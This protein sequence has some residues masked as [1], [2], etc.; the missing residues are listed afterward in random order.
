MGA[1]FEQIG[2]TPPAH[3]ADKAARTLE[4]LASACAGREEV[5][6]LAELLT[7][8]APVRALL[9]S[10]FG[11]SPYLT[12]LAT[13][14]PEGLQD[15]LASD[16]HD[17]FD[18]LGEALQQGMANAA[19]RDEAM[20][21]LRLYKQRVALWLA[22]ADIG[23][24]WGVD[25]VTHVLSEAAGTAISAAVRYLFAQAAQAGK[26]TPSDPA[27]PEA[28]SG[29]FVLGLGKLGAFE[30][31]Y[32]SDVDLIIFYDTQRAA[33]ADG[34]EPAPFFVRL[35]RDLVSLLQERTAA[36]YVFRTDLRLRPD[37]GATQVAL[38]TDAGFSY[39]ESFGQNWERAAL[40]KA[41]VVAGDH[42]AGEEFLEQLAPFV[43]RKYLDYAAIADI[44]TMKRRVHEFKGHG[45]IAVAG[46][47]V[48]LGRGGIR[49]IEF[50]VQTHQLIAGGRQADLRSRGTLETLGKLV[51]RNWIDAEAA[52]ELAEAYRYLRHVEHRIQ[53]IADEQTHKIPKGIEDLERVAHFSGSRDARSFGDE[54]V[55]YLKCVQGHY[56]GLFERLPEGASGGK[57]TAFRGDDDNPETMAVL[58]EFGFREPAKLLEVV[59]TWRSGRYAAMRSER[60]RERLNEMLPDLLEALG[61]TAEPDSALAAFDRFLAELPAGVQLFSLLGANTRL[62]RLIADIM[63]TAPRLASVLGRRAQVLDAVLDPGFFGDLPPSDALATLVRETVISSSDYQ[64]GLDQA[65]VVGAEQAFLIGV[66]VLSGTI[67]AEQAGGAYA[68]LAENLIAGLHMIVARE[69]ERSHGQMPGGQA[70]VLAMGK[71]G[72]REMTAASDLDLIVVYDFDETAG[73]STGAKPIGG[74]Q[75]YARFTQRLISALTVPTAEGSL[76]EVDM[77]LRPSGNAGPVAAHIDSFV[78]YQSNEAWSW[79]HLALTRARV[80]A[81]SGPLKSTIEETIRGVLCRKRDRAKIAADVREMRA[82]I[83]KEKGTQDIWDLKQARGGLIDLEFIS[84][85]LQ[86]VSAHEHPDIL[87]QSSCNALAKLAGKGL[88]CSQDADVLI[89]AARLLHDLTQ[90]LRLCLDRPFNAESANPGLK[91]LLARAAGQPDFEIL[92]R[93]LSETQKAVHAVF[94]RVIG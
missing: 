56:D 75:Y 52:G 10:V 19:N 58:G 64:D 53:M 34:I 92:E 37:P 38:S 11:S 29:Y 33:L 91:S 4:E 22:L 61:A 30:L 87:D 79:E 55:A 82:R 86:I 74:G 39:Y 17:C 5:A 16:P 60:A 73:A 63:G 84:Q 49:E 47:D 7:S 62:L 70:A 1:F 8:S 90:L 3:D 45:E 50:F 94:D 65:R 13:R 2:Q 57:E 25:Q 85:Y 18:R 15:W 46:H 42:E 41:R 83:E 54:L 6:G 80:V 68:L 69:V 28:S 93:H 21:S 81:G 40:I 89:P 36:G 14:D 35:T 72:G 51:E 31:N 77:R 88:L 9:T 32:S 78:D 27:V 48:K 26:F 44:H 23:N 24:V 66:R 76:Y 43:W 12:G 67:S 59:R 71:L 20:R